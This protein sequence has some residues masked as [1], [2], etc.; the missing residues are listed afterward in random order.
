[1]T[2]QPKKEKAAAPSDAPAAAASLKGKAPGVSPGAGVGKKAGKQ[3]KEEPAAKHLI[4]DEIDD[5]FK[6][7]KSGAGPTPATAAET[8]VPRDASRGLG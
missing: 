6:A 1:M 3:H 7:K 4:E 2:P 8:K 5:I